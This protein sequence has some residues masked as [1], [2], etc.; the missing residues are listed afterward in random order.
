[1]DRL[2]ALVS[3]PLGSPGRLPEGVTHL[4]LPCVRVL[5]CEIQSANIYWA[6]I[7]FK[8]S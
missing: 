7:T 1:M 8:V 4:L 2:L 3:L 5:L 6:C